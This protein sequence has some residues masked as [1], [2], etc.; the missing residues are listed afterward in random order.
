MTAATR[1]WGRLTIPG[2]LVF[3]LVP[4]LIA[5]LAVVILGAPILGPLLGAAVL[6]NLPIARFL[7]A[8]TA[9]LLLSVQ[10][11]RAHV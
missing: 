4:V 2:R 7:L 11:G 9:V 3:L 10:I 8:A 6:D 1:A 5:V